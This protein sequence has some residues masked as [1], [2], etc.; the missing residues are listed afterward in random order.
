MTEQPDGS[1]GFDGPGGDDITLFVAMSERGFEALTKE[2]IAL[3]DIVS[4]CCEAYISHEQDGAV[5]FHATQPRLSF[6][7]F[8][9]LHCDKPL[10]DGRN[11]GARG[12][13]TRYQSALGLPGQNPFGHSPLH[14]GHGPVRDC[15]GVRVLSE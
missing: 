12:I 13:A 8:C 5:S 7:K 1:T 15:V 14:R 6:S 3:G 2:D 10:Y 9:L 4:E 11:L